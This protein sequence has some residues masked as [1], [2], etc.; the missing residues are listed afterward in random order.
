MNV[1]MTVDELIELLQSL[2]PEAHTYKVETEGCDCTGNA[3]SVS[4]EHVDAW[5]DYP[6]RDYV[7][8]GRAR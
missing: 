5:L 4:I 2:P 7:L 6:A 1:A 3:S 8:I